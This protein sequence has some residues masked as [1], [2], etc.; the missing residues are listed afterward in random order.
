M[1]SKVSERKDNKSNFG[2][3]AKYVAGLSPTA[4]IPPGG[5]VPVFEPGQTAFDDIASYISDSKRDGKKVGLILVA[6]CRHN[7]YDLAVA[8][9]KATQA[10]NTRAKSNKTYHLILSFRENDNPAPEMIKEI[11]RSFCDALGFGEHQRI[12]ALHVNTEHPHLHIAINK[13]HPKTFRLHN[14]FRDYYIRDRVCREM[15]QKFGLCVDNGVDF[16]AKKKN[17]AV[18]KGLS[19]EAAAMEKHSGLM[20]FETWVK[21]AGPAE[22]L[23]KVLK[24]PDAS[25]ELVHRALSR[26]DL[27]MRKRGA[28]LVISSRSRK[29]FVKA[30]DVLREAGKGGIEKKLG[31]Y[32]EPSDEIMNA[33]A[34]HQYH[35]RALHNHNERDALYRQYQ[36]ERAE[37][38]TRKVL[39][40]RSLSE[41]RSARLS[42]I[43]DD[44]ARRR[45]R[46]QR[47]TLLG[48][49]GK[50][51]VYSKLRKERILAIDAV[52]ADIGDKRR[53]IY[54]ANKQL[55][56]Q[57]YLVREAVNGNDVALQVLRSNTKKIENDTQGNS[58]VGEKRDTPD[59]IYRNLPSQICKNGNV[60]YQVDGGVIRDEGERISVDN[61]SDQGLTM[62]L[63]MSTIRFGNLINIDGSDEFKTRVVQ[64]AAQTGM[65]IEFSNQAMEAARKALVNDATNEAF[66]QK[67]VDQTVKKTKDKEEIMVEHDNGP[68][69]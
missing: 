33:K 4:P 37:L 65:E 17:K 55:L 12:A 61:M 40:L 6:N 52:V 19:P 53:S 2:D 11:E 60:F 22:A 36:K 26:Y 63:R 25:W 45:E 67:T 23:S 8:E 27:V 57:D 32:A 9:I 39:D 50:R 49:Q 54:A 62:A 42:D 5:E 48:K 56:W 13:I 51:S 46:V 64:V 18:K 68:E 31:P 43:S 10:L 1:I 30:S 69:L 16:D 28:G 3:I 44:F 38:K 14:P 59:F 21:N 7:E 66:R 15:E 34:K 24:G 47:D 29:L 20:S 58:F 35:V 41:E